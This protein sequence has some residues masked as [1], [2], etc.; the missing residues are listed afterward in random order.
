M[1]VL[2]AKSVHRPMVRVENVNS[3]A[4]YKTV[5]PVA[6]IIV[7]LNVGDTHAVGTAQHLDPTLD[8]PPDLHPVQHQQVKTALRAQTVSAA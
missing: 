7:H 2:T 5:D 8:L 1:E 3:P 6:V 4:M